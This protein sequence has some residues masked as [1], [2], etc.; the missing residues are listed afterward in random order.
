MA[1]NNLFEKFLS[2]F[3]ALHCTET[4][5]IK[6]TNDLLLTTDRGESGIYII[7]DLSVAFDTIDHTI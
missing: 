2:G 5:L 6:V 1:Q 3:R 7:L 4:A